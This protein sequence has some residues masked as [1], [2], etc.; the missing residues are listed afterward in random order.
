M[1]PQS[2]IPS[3]WQEVLERFNP[4]RTAYPQERLVH[5]LFEEQVQRTPG[6]V[7][8]VY[9]GDSITYAELNAKAN[10]LAHYLRE[11]QIG[12]D[13]LV[14]ICVERSL[15]MVI[16]LLGILKAGGAYVPL[17]PSYPRERLQAMLDDAVP[18]V[19]L[20]QAHLLER[21]PSTGAQVSTLDDQW[22]EIARRPSNDLDAGELGLISHHL[23]YVI[24]TSGSTGRPKGVA[25]EHRNTVNLI[26]WARSAMPSEIFARTLL[27]TSLNF[28]LSVYEC[29]VPLTLGAT[30]HVVE[31]A[32]VLPRSQVDV[33]LI[34][35]VPSAIRA[36]VDSGHIPAATR[37]VN[38][39]G[40]A[41]KKDVVD[42]I[43]QHSGVEYV[44][45]LYGPS[46]TTTYSSWIAMSR[47]DGFIP[48]IGRPIANTYFYILDAH[49]QSVPIGV[50]GEIYI[51]GAGVTR[52]YLSRPG[53]TAERFIA[54]PFSRDPQARMYKTGDLA[55]WRGDG[56]IVYLGRNDTQVKIRGFRIEL[57]EIEARLLQ[58]PQLK[59]AVVLAREDEPGERH[60]VAYVV[61]QKAS[62]T[63]NTLSVEMLRA[64]LKPVL[65]DYML[66]TAFMILESLPLTLNGKVNRRA[67]PAPP[68]SREGVR[69]YVAPCTEIEHTLAT[70]WTQVLKVDC[71]GVHDNFVELGGDSLHAMKLIARIAA[72]LAVDVSVV[73][74]LQ[75]PTIQQIAKLVESRKSSGTDHPAG[76]DEL[77]YEEG[78]V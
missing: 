74:V 35:T 51:G 20:T 44:C 69:G 4:T 16:G 50:T 77:E 41:L 36:V 12:P 7:A 2:E 46:E 11:R 47:K 72:E 45:N 38:L 39:A 75:S 17:D 43:F 54:D 18:P 26:C 61:G 48:T 32:M 22:S 56:N 63:D 19:L 24:Y 66:P 13:Q 27:S 14:G 8:V 28:D 65:P 71:V 9:K 30:I 57:G 67:L 15:E 70:L 49:R 78:V 55:Y 76:T 23:A 73:E 37:V 59:E 52:G 33:T 34:N 53:L 31:N 42:L 29:F 62:D 6:S 58:H 1:E 21:L 3:E 68:R 25:I 5:E 60:L 40:E 10:R 64:H